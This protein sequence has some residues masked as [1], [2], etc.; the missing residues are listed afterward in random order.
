MKKKIR[1]LLLFII[2][3]SFAQ[4]LSSSLSKEKMDLG[5]TVVMTI[6]IQNLQG[7][8]VVAAQKNALMPIYIEEFSDEITQN[9]QQYS[10]RIEFTIFEEGKYSIPA[11]EFKIG[12]EVHRTI[13]YEIEVRNPAQP[14]DKI[15]DIMGNQQVE[16]TLAD[17]WELYKWYFL[18][19]I[20][21]LIGIIGVVFWIKKAKSSPKT[22]PQNSEKLILKSLQ[23]LQARNYPQKGEY[24]LFYIELLEICRAFLNEKYQVPA[25]ILLTDDLLD[26]IQ[27]SGEFSAENQKILAE[28]FT[29]G[30][31]VKFAKTLPTQEIME[32]DFQQIKNWILEK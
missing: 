23:E 32:R 24:R 29:R 26:F 14:Q 8:T 20:A 10:R 25:Q 6:N 28:I 3:F 27:K 18:A 12:D 11:L 22:T 7:K 30:D 21:V 4:T 9:A 16:L 5:E 2:N 1:I 17:Y 13:P 19:V 31:L 15:H